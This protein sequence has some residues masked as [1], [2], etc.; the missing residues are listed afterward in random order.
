MKYN[1]D[2]IQ[3]L[4]PLYEDGICSEASKAIVEEHLRECSACKEIAGRLKD[5]IVEETLTKEKD[6]VLSRYQK[7]IR[8]K[9]ATI[10]MATAS[11]LFIPLIICL[12]CNIVIGHALD[13][14]F[15]VF[16]AM[17]LAASLLVVPMVLERKRILW[18]IICSVVSLLLLLLTCCVYTQG[19][20]FW[21][22]SSACI[23]GL[24]IPFFPFVVSE[25]PIGET[26]GRHKAFL[27]MLWDSLWLYLLLIA[28]GVHIRADRAYWQTAITIASYMLFI[29]WFWFG[30]IRYVKKDGW[31]KAGILVMGTGIWFG[32]SNNILNIFMPT[33][34]GYGLENLNFKAGLNLE[35]PAA[36]NANILFIIIVLSVCIGGAWIWIGCGR[37]R[38]NADRKDTDKRNADERNENKG[39]A[40]EKQA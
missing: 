17:L 29:V 31:I 18:T 9:T 1:C 3:D 7:S 22:A 12:I 40:D 30:I 4:L 6:T 37:E 39:D 13:W 25:L 14:F 26:L 38:K 35:N 5:N 34:D 27:T 33:A 20:W 21:V 15:I 8:K 23:L 10:G 24:S 19:N 32:L 11:I 2:V 36:F 28:C 16:T